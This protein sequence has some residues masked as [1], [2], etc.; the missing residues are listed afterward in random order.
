[1]SKTTFPSIA[2]VAKELRGHKPYIDRDAQVK[3][4]YEDWCAGEEGGEAGI[5]VRLQ[6]F[7][8]TGSWDLHTG[9]AQYDT[10]HRGFWG[11][12]FLT[13]RSNCRDLARDLISEA[14]DHAAQCAD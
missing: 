8:G 6:V 2:T 9:D 7:P 14:R 5:D 1:M 13:P 3:G 4:T 10:D 12:G 11:C